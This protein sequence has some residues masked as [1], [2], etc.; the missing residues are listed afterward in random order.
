[1]G[2]S[3]N[4]T[5]V[6]VSGNLV[7]DVETRTTARGDVLA[8]FRIASTVKRFDRQRG[9]WVDGDTCFWNVTAWRWAAQNAAASLAKGHPVVVH[10]KVRQRVVDR[11][12]NGAPPGVVV[13][14]TYTDIDA[15]SFG[16]DLSRCR[17]A[18]QRAPM[19]PQTAG[20][21]GPAD[22]PAGAPG[23]A[24]GEV[25]G[26][27]GGAGGGAEAADVAATGSGAAA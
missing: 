12:V 22:A 14:T 10:G 21:G 24:G 6:T 15:V 20:S 23:G 1:M 19:G 11:E 5:M 18:Y 2:E 25:A 26:E 3:M 13:P 8:R 17:S 4:E 7:S 9:Q 16:L 27:T